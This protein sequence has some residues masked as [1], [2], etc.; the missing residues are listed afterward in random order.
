MRLSLLCVLVPTL[1]WGSARPQGNQGSRFVTIAD[2]IAMNLLGDP[3]QPD[4]PPA[5]LSP[6]RNH[7]VVVTHRGNLHNNSTDFSLLLFSSARAFHSPLPKRLLMLSSST[8]RPAIGQVDWLDN[9]T[10]IFLGSQGWRTTQIYTYNITSKTLAKRTNHPTDIVAFSATPQ[11]RVL[12][13][14]A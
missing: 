3:T 1:L 9:D 10:L 14:F 13:F 2:S 6:D 12:H 7:F 4:S 5:N 11:G 8:S